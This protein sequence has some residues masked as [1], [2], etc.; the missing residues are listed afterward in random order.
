MRT[1][2]ANRYSS[3][4][5]SLPYIRDGD[6]PVT[7]TAEE[8]IEPRCATTPG[9]QCRCGSAGRHRACTATPAARFAGDRNVASRERSA[10]GKRGISVGSR[11]CDSLHLRQ[12]QHTP[13]HRVGSNR[14]R[15]SRSCCETPNIW[16]K[17]STPPLP[18]QIRSARETRGRA[19]KPPTFGANAAHPP[20]RR[21][22]SAAKLGGVLPGVSPGRSIGT[23]ARLAPQDR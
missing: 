21:I 7:A 4:S 2:R 13:S 12:T 3:D 20:R 14:P 16:G 22:R 10:A 23:P 18:R 6:A 8:N 19:A 11:V 15:N 17:R 9:Y 5:A 1:Q